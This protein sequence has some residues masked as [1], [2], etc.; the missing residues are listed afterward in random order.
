MGSALAST[1]TRTAPPLRAGALAAIV[2]AGARAGEAG[3]D[4]WTLLG[5]SGGRSLALA[6]DPADPAVLYLAG[7]GGLWKSADAAA[8]WWRLTPHGGGPSSSVAVDPFDR[9]IVYGASF[10][11]IERSLDGGVSWT[12]A[13]YSPLDLPYRGLAADPHVRG[14]VYALSASRGVLK[15]VDRGRTWESFGNGL[16]GLAPFASLVADP[17][18]PGALYV[19]TSRGVYA[20]ADG[21]G[22]W[23]VGGAG[24]AG[25]PVSGSLCAAATPGGAHGDPST[26]YAFAPAGPS[27]GAAISRSTDGAASWVPVRQPAGDLAAIGF[28]A[29]PGDANRLYL[30]GGDGRLAESRDGG[31]AWTF[32]GRL[33][34][35]FTSLAAD[36]REPRVLYALTGSGDRY[37]GVFRSADGGATWR[38]ASRGLDATWIVGLAAAPGALYA[39]AADGTLSASGDFGASWTPLP[40]G[41]RG[42]AIAA[43]PFDGRHLLLAL[44]GG[45]LA[46]RD[47][48]ATWTTPPGAGPA[49]T[50]FL[51]FDPYRRGRA[52][53]GTADGAAFASA[54]GGASWAP[55]APFPTPA[56]CP[57]CF[58]NLAAAAF[59]PAD[60]LRL[61]AISGGTLFA[62]GDGGASWTALPAAG[63]NL[64]AVVLDPL[65]PETLYAGGCS[66]LRRSADGGASWR[67][68]GAGLPSAIETSGL[69]CVDRLAIDPRYPATLYADAGGPLSQLYRSTDGGASWAPLAAPADLAS[70]PGDAFLSALVLDPAD[71][72]RLY[73]ATYGLGVLAGRFAGAAPLRFGPPA[74]ESATPRFTLRAAWSDHAGG[75]GPAAPNPLGPSGGWFSFFA[76]DNLELAVKVLNGS[77]VGGHL[78]VFYTAL[79]D[80][81]FELTVED[82]ATGAVRSYLHPAGPAASVADTAALPA[83]PA[84]L[85]R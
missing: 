23:S 16:A 56:P 46:S 74:G 22:H 5:P 19:A 37:G 32:A 7:D 76:P 58:G 53:A 9:S 33:P 72:A 78:W 60:P 13:R 11:G 47:G 80:V 49:R 28:A 55:L 77:A 29:A 44:A 12:A 63:A 79:T 4:R 59:S 10:D 71:P 81:A 84:E 6:F 30:L 27:G 20:S 50:T 69:F 3:V 45:I 24:L 17:S 25:A 8:E 48:G 40:L 39:L 35:G 14:T 65:A 43:D 1:M 85:L 52:L 57:V 54:D 42:G 31:A 36:P 18:R 2:L 21:G 41:V 70:H 75:S 51:A 62:S 83:L 64:R 26:L 38:A 61:V 67:P 34:I 15:S 73:A 66:G 68:V 82:G